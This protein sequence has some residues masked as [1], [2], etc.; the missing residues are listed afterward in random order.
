MHLGQTSRRLLPPG[1][2]DRRYQQD[3]F[4]IWYY[5]PSDVAIAFWQITLA[6]V[7]GSFIRR[8]NWVLQAIHL[9]SE[10]SF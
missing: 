8:L 1:K 4:C 3:F 2:Y 6:L 5:E 7:M 10:Q 9:S